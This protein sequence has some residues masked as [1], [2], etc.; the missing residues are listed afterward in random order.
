[1]TTDVRGCREVVTD[2]VTG[3][4]VPPRSAEALASALATLIGD[5]GLRQRLRRNAYTQFLE[6]FTRDQSA[7]ALLPA[8]RSL[9]L[10]V[11]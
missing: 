2:R 3:L 7:D 4:L 9:G 1:V 10:E 11:G 6:R 5:E 8:M